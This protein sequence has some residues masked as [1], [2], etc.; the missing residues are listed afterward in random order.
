MWDVDHGRQLTLLRDPR[1]RLAYLDPLAVIFVKDAPAQ[2]TIHLD[3]PAAG[4]VCS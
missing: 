1:W 4:E 2:P 3:L